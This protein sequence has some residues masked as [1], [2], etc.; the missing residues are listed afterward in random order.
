VVY[1]PLDAQPSYPVP[2]DLEL[3]HKCRYVDLLLYPWVTPRP[4]TRGLASQ[5][6]GIRVGMVVGVEGAD[7]DAVTTGLRLNEAEGLTHG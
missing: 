1:V 2:A 7:F 5:L 4:P 3:L 6:L